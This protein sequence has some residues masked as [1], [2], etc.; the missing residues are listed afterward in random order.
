MW[1]FDRY[2]VK[3]IIIFVTITTGTSTFQIFVLLDL[4]RLYRLC[5]LYSKINAY[6]AHHFWSICYPYFGFSATFSFRRK[7]IIFNESGTSL[8]AAT[9]LFLFALGLSSFLFSFQSLLECIVRQNEWPT[10]IPILLMVSGYT[11]PYSMAHT[12]KHIHIF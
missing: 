5:S 1:S 3:V 12:C 9:S 10:L 7:F 8:F 6:E 4:N 11:V 2:G